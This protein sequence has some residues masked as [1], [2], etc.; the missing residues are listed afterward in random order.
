MVGAKV[1]IIPV[2]K[3]SLA[4]TSPIFLIKSPF[5]V[6]PKPMLCGKIVAPITLL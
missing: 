2:D 3:S 1:H 4:T 5:L 6:E